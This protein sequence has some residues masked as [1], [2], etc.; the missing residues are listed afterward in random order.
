MDNIEDILRALAEDDDDDKRA[1]S[2]ESAPTNEQGGGLFSG[3]DPE[4]LLKMLSLFE[5]FNQPDD[6]ERFL[7]ALKPLL[8]EE[9]RPKID[10]AVRLMKLFTLLPLLGESG[11]FNK[12]I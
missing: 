2:A 8:R 3:L 11:L 1:D 5:T 10:S 6:N 4:M 12:L 9:N 7:L